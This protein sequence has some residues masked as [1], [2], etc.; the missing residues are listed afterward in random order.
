[1]NARSSQ[2]SSKEAAAIADLAQALRVA[3][4]HLE[5]SAV[6]IDILA[7][8]SDGRRVVI[9]VKGMAARAAAASVRAQLASA[10]LVAR[11]RAAKLGAEGVPIVAVPALSDRAIADLESFIADV[12][13]GQSW[14]AVDARGRWHLVGSALSGLEPPAP[15]RALAKVD[16]ARREAPPANP[17]SDLGQWMLKVLLA[18][19][20]RHLQLFGSE[21]LPNIRGVLDLASRAKVAP[22]KASAQVA[23]LQ[24]A[25]YLERSRRELRLVR[26]PELLESWRHAANAVVQDVPARF[27]LPAAEPAKRLD[28]VLGEHGEAAKGER[29]CLG[30]FS[31]AAKHDAPFVRGAP[32]HLY[33]EAHSDDDLRKLGLVAADSASADLNLRIARFPEAV[34]RGARPIDGVPSA[35]LLQCWLDLR[36]HPARGAELADE[37][38]EQLELGKV[39]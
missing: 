4:W 14:G 6:G 30:L 24:R 26:V 21:R 20:V 13:P 18:P 27:A 28:K 10:L 15:D 8:Q 22:S 17:F 16:D 23:A 34:F 35:D 9:E 11:A 31:A 1:M 19:R 33:A 2:H 25:G 32:R 29:L 37:I 3:G 39:E 5:R 7:R 12:A 38:A 36:G